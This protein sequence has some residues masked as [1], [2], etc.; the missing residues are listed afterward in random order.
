MGSSG[1][2]YVTGETFSSDFPTTAGALQTSFRGG[3]DAFV[4][5]LNST[6]SAL[7]YSTYLG[8]SNFDGSSGV[9]VDSSGDTYVTGSTQ[10][11]DFP[12]TPGALQT[13]LRGLSA[14]FVSKL[15]STGSALVYSTYLGGSFF[16]G[17]LG[18]VV[19]SSGDIYVTGITQSI[20]FP[21]T[22]GALQ[23]TF[24]GFPADAF[25]SKLNDTGSAL[26]YSTYLGGSNLDEGLGVAVD[27]SGGAYVTGSTS[28][29]DF[30]VTAGAL[31]TTFGGSTDAFVSK[32]LVGRPSS[33]APA[34][35][36][37]N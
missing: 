3:D 27:S 34:Q 18:V 37:A 10:S 21:T 35:A 19:D 16:E 11:I 33:T 26:L 31:Q 29:N 25:F 13:T 8:G 14:A 12:T 5:K 36:S 22:P 9:A 4:S 20:D 6:G 2:A 30:P 28:S 1:H 24:G 32:I 7:V 17:G 23:A 15:N